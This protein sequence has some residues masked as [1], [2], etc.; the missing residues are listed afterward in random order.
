M[1]EVV[2]LAAGLHGGPADPRY[3]ALSQ[4]HGAAGEQAEAG[5]TAVL[6]GLL[7]RQLKPEADA[8]RR[9]AGGDASPQRLVQAPF[10]EDG[11]RAR[12]R[13]NS[14]QH[15][16]AGRGHLRWRLGDANF[17]A[18]AREGREDG[19]N[20]ARAVVADRD[21]HKSPL[22]EGMPASSARTA[23]RS[24]RPTALYADSAW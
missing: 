15:G 12:R 6:V 19:A 4:P 24:A 9:F 8:E 10:A 2:G 14:G 1:G 18:Q 23:W 3:A 16:E 13:A 7:E 5:D 20:V 21:L 22:V 11:H 17:G